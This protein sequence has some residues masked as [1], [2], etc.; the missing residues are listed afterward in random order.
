MK[1]THL[2]PLFVLIL[3]SLQGYAQQISKPDPD[4]VVM[5]GKDVR[6][7]I[8]TAGTIRMEWAPDGKF[9]DNSSFV[10]VDRHLP[11]PEYRVRRFGKR[12][13]ITTSRMEVTYIV[14]SGKFTNKNL[15][16][17]S[18]KGLSGASFEWKPGMKQKDNLKGT[19]RTLDGYDGNMRDGKEMPIEDG[20]VARD[21]W[22]LIDD[23]NSLLFDG[24]GDWSWVTTR[25]DVRGDSD[26]KGAQD[27]YFMAYGDDY[28]QALGDFSKFAGKV[29]LPP[30]FAFGYWWSRYW[31]YSDTE[32]RDVINNFKRFDVPL[33]VMVIDMDWHPTYY[34]A[35]KDEFGQRLGWTGWSWNLGLFPDPDALL[36]W[37]GDNHIK[38]TL[39]LHPAS[40]FA[41][42]EDKYAEMAK[43][44]DFDTTGGRYIPWQ[45]SNKKFIKNFFDIEIHPLEKAGVDFWW[46]DWQQ[47]LYD[48]Q[49]K[50]LSNTWWLNYVF[51]TEKEHHGHTRPML[52]HRWG[53]LGNHRYQ[54]GFSGDAVIDWPSLDFQPYFT[55][56]ASNVLYG[57][58][59]HDIGGH[60]FRGVKNKK[61][62]P[63]MYARWMQ[64]GTFSPIFRTHSSKDANI[65]KE[66]WNFR[67]DYYDA[68]YGAIRLRYELVP[69]IYTTAREF[70]D[71]GI[72]LCR[73]MYYDYPDKE[74]AYDVK[75]EYMFGD[76][77]LIMPI[78]AP[79][80]SARGLSEVSV[81]LPEGNDW[82]E[83]QTGT[84]LKGG[85]TVERSF[86]INEYPVYVKAGAIIP[87]YDK[88]VNNLE[89]EPANIVVAV[90][91]GA[92]GE[93]SLYEDAGDDK[94]YA[95]HYAETSFSTFFDDPNTLRLIVSQRKGSY[96]GMKGVRNLEFKFFGYPQ[97]EQVT[98]NGVPVKH[99][100]DGDNLCIT[101]DTISVANG[102]GCSV[103]LKFK[104]LTEVEINDGLVSE[105]RKMSRLL[106][107]EKYRN[108]HVIFPEDMSSA[109]ETP[110]K[111]EYYPEDFA[112]NIFLFRDQYAKT[113][114]NPNFEADLKHA[115]EVHN[116][117][118]KE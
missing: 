107:E 24:A 83:W 18:A 66:I 19:Y 68:L 25:E 54:I 32:V 15:K 85:R 77:M 41:P 42:W 105:F 74:T 95:D 27:W 44:M 29:P 59:S 88:T 106:K 12:L 87:M 45:G 5:A 60:Y 93:G 75:D 56:C 57:Y 101:V 91:P 69:Y 63:E 2:I 6:F 104:D 102:S 48:K 71:T 82:Y 89:N 40:G 94:D 86:A 114:E 31:S 65:K 62:N 4:A 9:I 17:V 79:M 96:E 14:G 34:Q 8:L 35:G 3:F 98:V 1:K 33:D 61:L 37:M 20:L 70:Y 30:R 49:V 38:T 108:D 99:G 43:A 36:E 58:W 11:V 103:V 72:A 118:V 81:W 90:F 112:K 53:G 26:D 113:V 39:N 110:R 84:M 64:F 23:S 50:G 22:T 109:A 117:K 92:T 80:D 21:G 55:A 116:M 10:A 78:T 7:T 16:I 28:K 67:G 100:Y 13:A 97:P 73:P 111:L 46:L 76:D 115:N 51:F 47:W 52:Y